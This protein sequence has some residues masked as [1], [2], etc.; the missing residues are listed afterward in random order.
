[1]PALIVAGLA[2]FAAPGQ[3]AR[4]QTWQTE[5]SISAQATVT[6]NASFDSGSNKESDV[7]I[8]VVPAFSFSRQGDRLRANGYV[9]LNMIGYVQGTETSRILPQASILG[10]V[11]AVERFFFIEGAFNVSQD[12]VNPFLPRPDSASTFNTYTYGQARVS[13][14]IKGNFSPTLRYLL[15][16]D[17]TY[18]FSTQTDAELSNSYTGNHF[19]EIERTPEPFGWSVLVR[20]EVTRFEDQAQAQPNLTYDTAL[21]RLTAALT[22]QLIVGARVGYENTNY[23]LSDTSGSIYGADVAWS[24]TPVDRVEGYWENRFFG[25]SY[26]LNASHR[27]PQLAAGLGMSRLL[28][29]YPQV[30]L[31]LPQTGNVSGMLDA[32]LISRYPDPIERSRQVQDL[33]A[34]QGLP[35]SIPG[36]ANIYTESANIVT[37]GTADLA[38]IGVRNTL[39][40]LLFYSETKELPDARLPPGFLTFTNSEQRG[41]SVTLAHRLTPQATLNAITRYTETRGLDLDADDYTNQALAQLQYTHQLAPRSNA[42]AGV[43]Y[44]VVSTNV[45]IDANEAALLVG[46][47]H[48]F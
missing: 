5:A 14:Y 27:G 21:G 30:L 17:N 28:S 39:L 41:A 34:R 31:S 38:L 44:Q 7:I 32:I 42:F 22:P 36:G 29:T 6:N 11:E 12:L 23:T 37:S 43:R 48:R 3:I 45:G 1:V 33:I 19:G 25:P 20:R 46:F 47:T 13:P 9:A 24:P 8:N 4:A 26:Q 18:T 35:Q 10:E 15:R 2:V 16:S 40:F